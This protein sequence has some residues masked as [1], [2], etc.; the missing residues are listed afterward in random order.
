MPGARPRSSRRSSLYGHNAALLPGAD[1]A[2]FCGEQ[3]FAAVNRPAIAYAVDTHS[4]D[5]PEN[6]RPEGRE[7]GAAL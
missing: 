1:R 4:D 3:A 6:R 7:G 5:E 2:M